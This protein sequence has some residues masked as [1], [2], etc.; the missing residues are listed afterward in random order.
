MKLAPQ[1]IWRSSSDPDDYNRRHPGPMLDSSERHYKV[2]KGARVKWT[3]STF[4]FRSEFLLRLAANPLP[5]QAI[6]RCHRV[7]AESRAFRSSNF[8]M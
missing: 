1:L 4:W 8:I 2:L 7:P 5:L 6:R 3:P